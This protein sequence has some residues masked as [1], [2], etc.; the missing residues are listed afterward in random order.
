MNEF[1]QMQDLR[2]TTTTE[3]LDVPCFI[4]DVYATM[5]D[6]DDTVEDL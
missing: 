5:S 6:N 4:E 2:D 1:L 3:W